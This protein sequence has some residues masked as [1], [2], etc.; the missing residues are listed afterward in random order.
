MAKTIIEN[1]GT[2][3]YIY[4]P[5][6]GSINYY[7]K[8]N[9]KVSAVN[10]RLTLRYGSGTSFFSRG[11][12]EIDTPSTT[13]PNSLPEMVKLIHSYIISGTSSSDTDIKRASYV[14]SSAQVLALNSTPITIVSGVASKELQVMS[15]AVRVKFASAAYATNTTIAIGTTSD[16]DGQAQLNCLAAASSIRGTMGLVTTGVASNLHTG[17]DLVISVVSGNPATGNSDV[18]VDI[19][20]REIDL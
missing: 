16:P 5:Q 7:D 15:A 19:T 12:S 18:V 17:E 11:I 8:T 14:L 6:S 13:P 20:Y 4:I 3:L 1:A 9:L 10:N 2:Q